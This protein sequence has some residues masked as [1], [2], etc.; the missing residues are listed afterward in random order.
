M[1]KAQSR[2][3]K[4]NGQ[5]KKGG[6]GT[7]RAANKGKG[8]GRGT[9]GRARSTGSRRRSQNSAAKAAPATKVVY[10]Y[11]AAPAAQNG[12]KGKGRGRGR[13][14]SRNGSNSFLRNPSLKSAGAILKE[15]GYAGAGA[16][17]VSTLS[18]IIPFPVTSPVM[19]LI[20]QGVLAWIVG[21]LG[22][23]AL[24]REQGTLMRLGG[25]AYAAGN[26]VN[27]QFPNLQAKILSFSPL[28][29]AAN[30]QLPPGAAQAAIAT[31]GNGGDLS[32]AIMTSDQLSDISLAHPYM[33][34]ISAVQRGRFGYGG[35]GGYGSY[36]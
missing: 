11:K 33:N 12:R 16:F 17:G 3:R 13:G 24:G 35:A 6:G 34:D 14:R 5:F 23:K 20:V 32:S 15:L 1:A 27:N 2:A 29:P 36:S 26:F 25:F 30:A 4:A 9:R 22:G 19:I 7:P 31:N 8:R 18:Q 21:W 28:R 10:R